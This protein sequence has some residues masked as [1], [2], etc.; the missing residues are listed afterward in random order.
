MDLEQHKMVLSSPD[1]LIEHEEGD[2][3]ISREPYPYSIGTQLQTLQVLQL[4]QFLYFGNFILH[5]IQLPQLRQ[6]IQI[7][8]PLDL[9][10][11]QIKTRQLCQ[12]FKSTK[13]A[14]A[15]G[16]SFVIAVQVVIKRDRFGS[17]KFWNE[18]VVQ[19]ELV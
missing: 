3:H 18:I 9:V 4:F 8:Y 1:V 10:K 7:A 6:P 13:L 2:V 15:V 16:R 12:G 14:I 11:T 17:V 5:T 19:V